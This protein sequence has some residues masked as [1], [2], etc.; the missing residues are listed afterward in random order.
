MRII[1]LSAGNRA[2]WFNRSYPDA[3]FVDVRP[4]VNPDI[5]ADSTALP[6][7]VGTD[8]D[9]V[10]FDPPHKNNGATGNMAG[11]YGHW[12]TDAIRQIVTGTAKEA[13][14]ITKPNALM[15]FKWNDHTLSL[16]DALVML[17][18]WWEPLFGHGARVQQT[19][20]S[21]T[22]WVMLRRRAD[23]PFAL[24]SEG[25][26]L[27]VPKGLSRTERRALRKPKSTNAS[28][29]ADRPPSAVNPNGDE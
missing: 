18:A 2:I 4:E 10:V 20:G 1:D 22:S 9:L 15:A 7:E 26:H 21:M 3:L 12:S 27:F 16:H 29:T 6:A 19:Y 23:E 5:V 11:N 8:F 28:A 25:E 17:S 14:R 24:A 13:W